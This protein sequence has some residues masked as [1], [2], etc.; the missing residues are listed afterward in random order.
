MGGGREWEQGLVCKLKKDSVFKK[1]KE[2][3]RKRAGKVKTR[4]SPVSVILTLGAQRQ[5]ELCS[6]PSS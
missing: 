1:I 3:K 6:R 5:V 4:H 2:R